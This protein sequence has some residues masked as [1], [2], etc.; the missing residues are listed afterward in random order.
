[1]IMALFGAHDAGVARGQALEAGIAIAL[2]EALAGLAVTVDAADFATVGDFDGL[3]QQV[4]QGQ[5]AVTHPEPVADRLTRRR[6]HLH[7]PTA[8]LVQLI[9][10]YLS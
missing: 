6:R 1:M 10:G 5:L 2:T 9:Q 3:A 4:V 8:G 7:Q